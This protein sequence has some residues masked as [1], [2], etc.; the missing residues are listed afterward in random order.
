M[1][2][3]TN[4]AV[5]LLSGGIDS[6]TAMAVARSRGFDLYALTFDYGQKSR[7]EIRASGRIASSMKVREHRVMGVDLASLGGSALTGDGN[8][9]RFRTEDEMSSGVPASYVPGRN[10]VFLAIASAWAEV[11]EAEAVFIGANEIDYSG[12]P[13]CRA[14]FIRAFQR[15]VD[16]GLKCSL[17]GRKVSI[18]AP[19]IDMSKS[20]IISLG[21]ELGVDYSLTTSCYE[22]GDS[23]PCGSCD[24][25]VFRREAGRRH[26]TP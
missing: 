13:D 11:L 17:E 26:S 25:C 1:H 14:G 19:L 10:T 21:Y 6:A 4:R 23:G 3:T 2:E 22:P 8:I 24:S 16:L 20:R 18:E 5:V 12:Y 9:P 15:V 7:V